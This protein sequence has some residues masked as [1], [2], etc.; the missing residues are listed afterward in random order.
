[1]TAMAWAAL[2][3]AAFAAVVNWIAVARADKRVEYVAK[4]LTMLALLVVAVMLE[5][6]DGDRRMW[7]V[8]AAVLSLAGDVFLMLPRDLFRAGLVSFLLAHL[9]YIGGLLQLPA[10]GSGVAVGAIVVVVLIATLGVRVVR[11]VR[12]GSNR[13]LLGPVV[14]YLIVISAMVVAAFA[15]GP[16]LAIVGAV[17]FYASDGTLAEQRFVRP[18][19]WAPVAVMVTYHL[20]QAALILSLAAP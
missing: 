5:P 9:C 2:G 4:P 20:G 1:M 19:P 3:V 13:G 10:S 16:L 11:A 17:T 8:G 14:T 12:A 15:T 6:A 18:H 7:F